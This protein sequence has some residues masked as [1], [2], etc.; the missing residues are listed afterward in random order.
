MNSIATASKLEACPVDAMKR[1]RRLADYLAPDHEQLDDRDHGFRASPAMP[2][3]RAIA[4]IEARRVE[5]PK[6]GSMRS[7]KAGNS[8]KTCRENGNG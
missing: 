4:P 6:D 8:S 1:L 2:M 3:N 7:T 5:T